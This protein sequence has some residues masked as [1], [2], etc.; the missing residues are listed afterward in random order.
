M[1]DEDE[2]MFDVELVHELFEPSTIKLSVVVVDNHSRETILTYDGFS[3]KSFDLGSNDIGHR[4]GFYSFGEVVHHN[5]EK[6]WL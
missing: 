1:S 4:L 3:N 6:S 2:P 5:E